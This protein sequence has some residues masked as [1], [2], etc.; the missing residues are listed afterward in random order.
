MPGREGD[1]MCCPL[2]F[3]MG[4]QYKISA[5]EGACPP[6]PPSFSSFHSF[7]SFFRLSLIFFLSLIHVKNLLGGLGVEGDP[8]A[9]CR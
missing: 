1:L 8:W 3:M 4:V 5:G 7:F 2:I 6:H 9:L